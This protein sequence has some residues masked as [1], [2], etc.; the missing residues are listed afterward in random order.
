MIESCWFISYFQNKLLNYSKSEFKFWRSYVNT[1]KHLY[2]NYQV[3]W[4][5]GKYIWRYTFIYL[6]DD[7]IWHDFVYIWMEEEFWIYF[8]CT[9]KF[10]TLLDGGG[11]LELFHLYC[12]ISDF[13]GQRRKFGCILIILQNSQHFWMFEKFWIY[14]I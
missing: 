8:I 9:A 13:F 12:K 7:V 5:S 4:K 3:T 10:L 2:C 6:V 1:F 14:S 11:I